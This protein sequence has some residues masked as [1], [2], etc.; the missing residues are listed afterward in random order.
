MHV[1]YHLFVPFIEALRTHLSRGKTHSCMQYV[2]ALLVVYWLAHGLS[3]TKPEMTVFD[4][5]HRMCDAC[6]SI[7][8]IVVG[9]PTATSVASVPSA[10]RLPELETLQLKLQTAL[11]NVWICL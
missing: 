2:I 10:T 7:L 6:L 8:E 9:F 4:N 5:G 1:S 11:A 3:Y